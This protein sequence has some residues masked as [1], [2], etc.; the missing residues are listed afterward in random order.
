MTSPT[1]ASGSL[2]RVVDGADPETVVTRV[3]DP[4]GE[5]V[6]TEFGSENE[7]EICA[8][9]AQRRAAV[10]RR[11]SRSRLSSARPQP[12]SSCEP[13]GATVG[14]GVLVHPALAALGATRGDRRRGSAAVGGTLAAA[15]RLSAGVAV[16]LSRWDR[17]AS[18]VEAELDPGIDGRHP[19]RRPGPVAWP[20]A[21]LVAA[22]PTGSSARAGLTEAPARR[23]A[24]PTGP[25]RPRP[26]RDWG[27]PVRGARAPSLA[28]L[29]VAVLAVT[30]AVVFGASLSR[31]TGDPD[32]YG[33]T[34][35]CAVGNC[36][37]RDCVAQSDR[38]LEAN[39]G[40][41]AWT[42]VEQ[43]HRPDRRC[44]GRAAG[45][46]A[47]HLGRGW[48]GGQILEGAPPTTPTRSCWP[49][50]PPARPEPE[51]ATQVA[52]SVEGGDLT[53]SP[54]SGLY[55]PATMCARSGAGRRSRRHRGRG[56]TGRPADL[57][58]IFDEESCRSTS[59]STSPR[60]PTT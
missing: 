8:G 27:V 21:V 26:R 16:V 30:A 55:R 17:S 44:R 22:A 46:D 25:T 14:S 2:Y 6:F 51:S 9:P 35:D 47:A 43:R 36:S 5:A 42:G 11:P 38:R 18:P 56:P 37:T 4:F 20:R 32:A 40:V 15:A 24:S 48:A 1:T 59:S 52:L 50:P 53:R 49:K 7:V 10:Q 3:A 60:M 57:R 45:R 54:S 28:A 34:W 58:S 29:P 13:S 31:A 39:A 33:W 19:R 23:R 41:A 12:S